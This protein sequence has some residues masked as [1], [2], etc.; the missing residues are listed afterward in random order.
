MESG[1]NTFSGPDP[2]AAACR[3]RPAVKALGPA[4][5]KTTTRAEASL[6]NR[7]KMVRNSSHILGLNIREENCNEAEMIVFEG[8]KESMDS[9]GLTGD[10]MH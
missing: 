2:V 10:E 3:S 9:S 6:D 1:I 5:E 7:S 8:E 4:P